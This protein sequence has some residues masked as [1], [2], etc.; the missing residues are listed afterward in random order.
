MHAYIMYMRGM[1]YNELLTVPSAFGNL[2]EGFEYCMYVR[3]TQPE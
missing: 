2:E 3:K 1:F